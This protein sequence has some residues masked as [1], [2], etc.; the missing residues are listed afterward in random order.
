M[1]TPGGTGS[2]VGCHKKELAVVAIWILRWAHMKVQIFH[3]ASRKLISCSK[4]FSK[5]LLYGLPPTCSLRQIVMPC[6]KRCLIASK[7]KCDQPIIQEHLNAFK[8]Q[9]DAKTLDIKSRMFRKMKEMQY[10]SHHPLW[11]PSPPCASSLPISTQHFQ[12]C[13]CIFIS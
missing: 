5:I 7:W 12:I 1:K 3:D 8:F 13:S 4:K 11:L 10:W 9:H 2:C 6:D